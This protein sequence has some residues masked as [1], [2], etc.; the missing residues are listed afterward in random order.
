M[1]KLWA[2]EC[3]RVF[4]DRLI[5]QEDRDSFQTMLAE[6][7]K[8]KFKKEWSGIVKIEPLLFASFVPLCYPGGDTTKKPFTNVYCELYDRAKT[9]R[10]AN[11]SLD[12]YNSMNVSKRMNLVLFDSA[13][14]HVVKIHRVITTEF[15]HALLIGVGG[16]GRK[17]LT[18]L[19]VFIAAYDTFQIEI[20]NAYNFEAWRDDM[21]EKLFM[22]CGVDEKATVFLLSD[23]QIVKEAF[24]EDVNNVLNNGEIP[25][26]YSAAEDISTVLENMREANK[27]VM[28]Y[29]VFGDQEIWADFL[30]K[31]KVNVHI[32][33]A[34]SPIGEDF[35]R[36]LRMFPSLVNCCAIDWFLPWP[37]Q[38]LETVAEYFLKDVSDLPMREGIVS[39]CV[40]MQLR[41]TQLALKY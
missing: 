35:K 8:D 31:A 25:N 22:N 3:L 9:R 12:S 20:T 24:L 38:A 2:H 30:R 32:V 19:A 37:K 27:N 41:T 36:R 4:Q 16:S 17:S 6:I 23:T 11:D 10:A 39:I 7:F 33:L 34:M 26:L 14:E 40:D 21:R 1:L 28:G 18:E 29:K 5:S 15:G 13:I